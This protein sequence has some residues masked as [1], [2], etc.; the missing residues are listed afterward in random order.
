MTIITRFA[1]SPSGLIHLGNVRTALFSWLAARRADGRFILRIEDSDLGRSSQA[2]IDAL[3]ADLRWLGLHWDEG[4]Q[5]GGAHGP[6]QQSARAAVYAD[7]YRIL[8]EAGRAYPCYCSAEEL[9]ISRKV[10]VGMG[11]APRYAGTCR[12]LTATDRAE[13]LAQG[14]QPSLRFHVADGQA[15]QFDDAVR[16]SQRFNSS[17][18]G[19][20]IIRRADASAAFFFCNAIDDA[21]M[22]VNLVLRGDD[23]LANTPRQILLLQALDLPVPNYGHLSLIVGEDGAPLSKRNGSFSITELRESGYLPQAVNNYLARLGHHVGSDSLLDN[24]ALAAHFDLKHL[25]RS[26]SRFDLQQLQYW[27]RQALMQLSAQTLWEW[28]APSLQTSVPLALRTAFVDAVRGNVGHPS[29]AELWAQVCFGDPPSS[30]LAQAQIAAV[31]ADFWSSA[32][33][34]LE[35]AGTDFKPLAGQVSTHTGIKGK[36]L[37]MPL[38]AALTGQVHGPE[39]AQLLPLIGKERALRRLRIHANP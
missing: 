19:D 20:F 39:M 36:A 18:I 6:Y 24:D 2:H 3:M 14:R 10:Q 9:E 32:T 11:Q 27:Q 15:V 4:P 12:H 16:G 35:Q 38:R 5:V 30:D 22:Q 26:P 21:L 33:A 29:E 31:S 37:F 8:E 1:P 23:H 7:Y 13:R 17:D 34:A 25:G 28:L